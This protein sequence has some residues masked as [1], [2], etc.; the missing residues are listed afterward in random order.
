MPCSPRRDD[1]VEDREQGRAAAVHDALAADLDD[2]DVG[3]DGDRAVV[4]RRCLRAGQRRAGEGDSMVRRSATGGLL[5]DHG[6]DV[7]AAQR[8]RE[9]AGHRGR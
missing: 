3:H 4:D 6:A 9:L 7:L 5:H 8:A 2:L 1:L